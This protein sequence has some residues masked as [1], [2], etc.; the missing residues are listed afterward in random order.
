[1]GGKGW[2]HERLTNLLEN[3]GEE[4]KR[5]IFTYVK[6]YKTTDEIFKSVIHSSKRKIKSSDQDSEIEIMLF[7]AAA[8]KSKRYLRLPFTRGLWAVDHWVHLNKGF[9]P[10][11]Q[12]SLS[13]EKSTLIDLIMELPVKLRE[14]VIL[15]IYCGFHPDDIYQILNISASELNSRW[16]KVEDKLNARVDESGISSKDIDFYIGSKRLHKIT[17]E[18]NGSANKNKFHVPRNIKVQFVMFLS[19][20]CI[21]LFV[22]Y[23]EA[24]KAISADL[25]INEQLE[26]T[27]QFPENEEELMRMVTRNVPGWERAKSD[28]LVKDMETSV[29]LPERDGELKFEKMYNSGEGMHL[30]YSLPVSE[31]DLQKPTY[32]LVLDELYIYKNENVGNESMKYMG[33]Y[34][35]N[36][37]GLITK[38]TMTMK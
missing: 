36:E 10:E 5:F 12:Q 23:Q 32:N 28:G 20:A 38:G 21:I 1:M 37:P 3:K 25:D 33:M 31:A 27:L 6:N 35:R 26:R 14:V 4:L 30:I 24:N 19:I 11:T 18:S 8:K 13:S 2:K 15:H 17:A 34:H 9:I 29:K 22:Q 7:E 16:V